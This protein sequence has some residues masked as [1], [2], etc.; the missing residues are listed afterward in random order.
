M[1]VS[2][3]ASPRSSTEATPITIPLVSALFPYHA[4]H[5]TNISHPLEIVTPPDHVLYGF[6]VDDPD[7]GRT[8]FVHLPPPHTASHRAEELSANFSEVLRPHDPTRL[9]SPK[10]T[11]PTSPPSSMS[12]AL[13]I[14]DSL[15]ALLDLAAD[16]IEAKSLLLVLDK[17]DRGNEGLGELLH[18]L[19]Y[20]GGQVVNP[21][22]LEGGWE[23]DP[24]RWVLV[25][26][27]L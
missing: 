8:A 17:H 21:G 26:L 10:V 24:K 22:C 2:Q 15:T 13:D 25:G 5:L 20:V 7:H 3:D 4:S 11:S 6:V 1:D 12:E 14:R 16:A 27:E 18:S 9:S 23:W 19:M